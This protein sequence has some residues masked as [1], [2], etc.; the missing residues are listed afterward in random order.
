M[1][2]VRRFAQR[3]N[4]E[5]RPHANGACA[6]TST[7]LLLVLVNCCVNDVLGFDDTAFKSS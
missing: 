2:K 1:V 6:S 4:T 3:R 5:Q 7:A